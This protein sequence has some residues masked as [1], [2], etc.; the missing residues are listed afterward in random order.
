VTVLSDKV[1]LI[2]GASSGIGRAAARLFAREGARVVVGGRHQ[3]NLDSVVEE[4]ERNGGYVAAVAGDVRDEAVAMELVET[5]SRRFGGLDIAVNNAGASGE[6]G[7]TSTLSLAD[8]HQTIDV[9]LTSAFLGAK[10]QAP[11]IV[12]RGGGAILFTSSFVGPSTGFPGMA[13]YAAAKAGLTGLVRVLAVE[14]GASRVRV[15]AILPGA[16]DTPSNVVNSPEAT[17]ATRTFIEGLHALKRLAS[18]EEIAR[19]MLYLVSDDASFVTGAA[20]AVDG[21]LT[22]ART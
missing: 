6:L 5:A 2:T 4:I 21:G 18:P 20:I 12:K 10:H 15:N 8:W 11:A 7:P 22:I 13:A 19:S 9:N 17:P 14:F 1:A 16:V 3:A